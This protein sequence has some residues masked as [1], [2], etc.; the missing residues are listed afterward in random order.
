LILNVLEKAVPN[1]LTLTAAQWRE[2]TATG[3]FQGRALWEWGMQSLCEEVISDQAYQ[4][5]SDAVG[6][7]SLFLRTNAAMAMRMIALP[8][9]DFEQ[10]QVLRPPNGFGSLIDELE[11]RLSACPNC[12]IFKSYRLAFV[13]RA[14]NTVRLSFVSG[15]VGPIPPIT[16]TKTILAMPRRAVELINFNGLFPR[17]QIDSQS[18]E[19]ARK[20]QTVTGVPAFKI[21]MVYE[22]P[23]WQN[24]VDSSGAKQGWPDGYSVTDLPVRQVY[25]GVGQ[26]PN[27]G[28]NARVI[29]A[30][31][32]DSDSATYWH[33]LSHVSTGLLRKGSDSVVTEIGPGNLLAAVERQLSILTGVENL[34]KPLWAGYV[35]WSE[36][37]YGGAW[38]EWAAGVDIT[39]AIP[40]LREPFPGLPIYL[41]GEAYSWFQAWIEG[42]LMSAERL[43]Q[44]KF[45]LAW[46]AEWLP[47]DYD[48]GP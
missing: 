25:W 24:F 8:L 13:D 18:R 46:P 27:T 11:K 16:A 14:T 10:G 17:V 22:T 9:P 48:L 30:A 4:F 26:G 44:D 31:Y 37:P 23:W 38:H 47:T 41:C 40:D 35:D 6:L 33:G 5:V 12:T 19:L 15:G 28:G 21:A 7:D 20:L 43:L 39:Q 42:A 3:Q 2:A 34:P 1:A 32:A 29:L 45:G 36:D